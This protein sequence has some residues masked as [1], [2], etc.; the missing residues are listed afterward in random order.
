[1]CSA[2]RSRYCQLS[3]RSLQYFVLSSFAPNTGSTTTLTVSKDLLHKGNA[4]MGV[5]GGINFSTAS[6]IMAFTGPCSVH[7]CATAIV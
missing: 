7:P 4:E 3:C 6:L 5:S 1:M 2:S